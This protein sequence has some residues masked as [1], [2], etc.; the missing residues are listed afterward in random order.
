MR[1]TPALQVFAGPRARAQL[2]ERGLRPADVRIVPGAAGGP[3]GLALNPLDRFLFGHWLAD[4]AHTVH[5]VGA[6]VG[7]WRMACAMLRNP[8]T[9]LAEL[10]E[11]YL[12]QRYQ[13]ASGKAP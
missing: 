10:A 8:D 2:R 1:S 4:S 6:S 7:A 13:H 9:A 3:K 12:Q 5:L 11:N